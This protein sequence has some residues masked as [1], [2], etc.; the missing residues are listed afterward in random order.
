MYFQRNISCHIPRLW[1]RNISR[2]LKTFNIYFLLLLRQD[3]TVEFCLELIHYIDQYHLVPLPMSLSCLSS[4]LQAWT[5]RPVTMYMGR[6][7][8]N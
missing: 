4:K 6:L 3:L 1:L 7:S 8:F 5:T 2:K